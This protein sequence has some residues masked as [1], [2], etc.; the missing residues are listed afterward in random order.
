MKLSY[1]DPAKADWFLVS[2]TLSNKCNYRCS[3]CP[4]RL[5]DGSTGHK[6]WDTVKN[7]VENFDANG[8]QICYRISGGEPTYWKH[9]ID[10]AK[11]VKQQGQ[12]FSF[13]TN[14]SQKVE[15]FA[16]ITE[17]TDGMIISYH[18]EFADIDHIIEV[19]KVMTC[20]VAVNLMML[21]D[22]FDQL[23]DIAERLFNCSD[24][25]MIWPKV[26]L[27]KQEIEGYPTN[28][29]SAYSMSQ[30]NIITNWPYT[31]KLDDTK[32]HRGGLLLDGK[33]INANDLI[34]NELN[35]HKGWNCWAGLDM[36]SIDMWGDIYR[37]ECQQGGKI[38]NLEKY[39]LPD[40]TI[41][42]GKEKC[43][44]LSDIYLRKELIAVQQL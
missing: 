4:S 35:A 24:N 40:K 36:I 7:F 20:P 29:V 21:P 44:C 34:V 25:V 15:Y 1:K 6:K 11:L 26:I 5:H 39:N 9:F 13:L 38:G 19:I 37:A 33:D 14:A 2:W 10:M 8:K 3:Y 27:D 17:H 23:L 32:L 43:Y 12:Y 41:T 22:N 28:E 31:R 30:Q 18:P 16:E 42:C